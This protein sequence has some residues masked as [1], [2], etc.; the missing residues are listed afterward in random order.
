[1]IDLDGAN[2]QYEVNYKKTT[3]SKPIIKG[4]TASGGKMDYEKKVLA[5]DF[6]SKRNL[7]A[8]GS[9]NC[10]FTYSL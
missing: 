4:A 3:V 9:L 7:L 8:V 1:M 5:C 2:T 6:S 10:F